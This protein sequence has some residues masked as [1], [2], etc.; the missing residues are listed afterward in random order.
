[1]KRCRLCLFLPDTTVVW[2]KLYDTIPPLG[3]MASSS[4]N[5]ITV[6]IHLTETTLRQNQ[7]M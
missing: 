7:H 2:L 5:L 6:I 4:L 3:R 1:M